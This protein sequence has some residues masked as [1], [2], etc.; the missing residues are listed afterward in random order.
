M[1]MGN[2]QSYEDALLALAGFMAEAVAGGRD[3]E[4]Y[5]GARR[6]A[7][8]FLRDEHLGPVVASRQSAIRAKATM[9]RV[10]EDV[11]TDVLNVTPFP[12]HRIVRL[13]ALQR[14]GE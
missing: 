6:M 13:A 14:G 12:L 10:E 8:L 3:T 1:A 5:E 2:D 11:T 4:A 9:A 7:E